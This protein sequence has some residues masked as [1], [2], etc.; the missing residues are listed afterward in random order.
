MVYIITLIVTALLAM[1]FT[2]YQNFQGMGAGWR[3]ATLIF[4]LVFGCVYVFCGIIA[5][6]GPRSILIQVGLA[7]ISTIPI[8]IAY[9]NYKNKRGWF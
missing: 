9:T 5:P 6:P 8:N 2:G 1:G 3:I 7:F 4:L